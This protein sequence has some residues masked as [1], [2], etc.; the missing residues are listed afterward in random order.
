[1]SKRDRHDGDRRGERRD[2][3]PDDEQQRRTGE[4]DAQEGDSLTALK[5]ILSKVASL[6]NPLQLTQEESIRLVE[7]LYGSV[8]ETD[9]RLAGEADDARKSSVLAQIQNATISRVG[10]KIVVDYSASREPAAE[11]APAK[12]AVSPSSESP[13]AGAPRPNRPP[14]E[15][16]PAERGPARDGQPRPTRTESSPAESSPAV[17]PAAEEPAPERPAFDE[18]APEEPAGES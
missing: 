17:R 10:D 8:L 9:V 12:P 2:S 16:G 11:A 1:V 5:A 6:L 7:Q 3:Q 4:P 13:S 14:A 18:P 15:R